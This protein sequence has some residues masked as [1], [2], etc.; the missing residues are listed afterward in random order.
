MASYMMTLLPFVTQR[1]PNVCVIDE[2]DLDALGI[3]RLILV[4][5]DLIL[6]IL[7]SVMMISG[8]II[9]APLMTMSITISVILLRPWLHHDDLGV[10][11]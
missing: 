2:R 11:M 10:T 7:G 4:A 3:L 1:I 8:L 5:L 9:I 6:V